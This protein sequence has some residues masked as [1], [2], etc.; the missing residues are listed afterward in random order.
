MNT[1]L[2]LATLGILFAPHAPHTTSIE[3]NPYSACDAAS[4]RQRWLATIR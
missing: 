4:R 3:I 2:I 1:R